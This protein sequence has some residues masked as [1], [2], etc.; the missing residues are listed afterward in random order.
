MQVYTVYIITIQNHREFSI[1]VWSFKI[2]QTVA[3][4]F[5]AMLGTKK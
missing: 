5:W 4:A 3:M 1:D 2:I